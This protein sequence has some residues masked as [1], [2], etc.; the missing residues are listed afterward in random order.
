MG[1]WGGDVT[2]GVFG[3]EV[4]GLAGKLGVSG[5]GKLDVTGDVRHP[6]NG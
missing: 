3:I 2:G 1:N 6:T 5:S 4:D